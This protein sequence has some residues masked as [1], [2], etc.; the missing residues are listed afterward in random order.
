MN[1]AFLQ[2]G[3]NRYSQPGAD[4]RGCVNDCRNLQSE[5]A[6]RGWLP[7]WH[8]QLFDADATASNI[9]EAMA[10]AVSQWVDRVVI[11]YSGH[12]CTVPDRN[13]D[14]LDSD[15][16]QAICPHDFDEAGVIVDDVLAAFADMIP[17]NRQ[18]VFLLD[19]CYSGGSSR[20][21]ILHSIGKAINGAFRFDTPRVLPEHLREIFL[22]DNPGMIANV[23]VRL[24]S[25]QETAGGVE[26][27]VFTQDRHIV[28]ATSQ[29]DMTSADSYIG[30]VWQG[31]GTAAL[32]YSWTNSRPDAS[33]L[34]VAAGANAWLASAG[35]PQRICLE[36]SHEN[37]ST[38]FLLEE[39]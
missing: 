34:S 4:L 19:S 17:P 32:L 26:N 33:F 39:I 3:I 38:P 14:E 29:P 10:E 36:G 25:G 15:Q 13:R 21:P 22:L 18:L 8:R 16:D 28:I 5:I 6:R 27:V 35:Y 24:R 30:S 2:I 37:L 12:G 11:Q 1:L 7:D 23:D 9:R 20:G 31:A